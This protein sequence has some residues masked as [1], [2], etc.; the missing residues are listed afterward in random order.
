MN[1][2]ADKIK[3]DLRSKC[4]A[5]DGSLAFN[6]YFDESIIKIELF[7]HSKGNL[8]EFGRIGG[9]IRDY[10][11]YFLEIKKIIKNELKLF[12]DE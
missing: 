4:E 10:Y 11:H 12:T 9:E 3:S 8:I 1:I 7:K 2:L 5:I 6:A